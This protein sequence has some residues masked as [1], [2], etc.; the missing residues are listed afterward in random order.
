MPEPLYTLPEALDRAE[1]LTEI[2]KKNPDVLS[3]DEQAL[4]MALLHAIRRIG[5]LLTPVA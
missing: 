4:V 1:E 2:F 3:P 5:E